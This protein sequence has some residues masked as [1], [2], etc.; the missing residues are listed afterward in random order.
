MFFSP[1]LFDSVRN[2]LKLYQVFRHTAELLE[3]RVS[4]VNFTK[5][6]VLKKTV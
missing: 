4:I 5:L 1:T 2:M 6:N 3:E